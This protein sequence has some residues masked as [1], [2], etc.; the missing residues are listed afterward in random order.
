M[1]LQRVG[2]VQSRLHVPNTR[3]VLVDIY[4]SLETSLL[5]KVLSGIITFLPAS[6]IFTL[7]SIT[8]FN[9]LLKSSF[10]NNA[11]FLF[12]VC[13]RNDLYRKQNRKD[14]KF[15]NIPMCYGLLHNAAKNKTRRLYSLS[16]AEPA[17]S[18]RER[19]RLNPGLITQHTGTSKCAVS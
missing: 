15:T 14:V 6:T 9:I 7:C 11:R 17:P 16:L 19:C 5:R 18:P 13:I 2:I 1:I 3:T 8:A 4:R 10:D 12:R